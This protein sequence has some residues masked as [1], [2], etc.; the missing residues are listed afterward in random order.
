MDGRS[1]GRPAGYHR[2]HQLGVLR[3]GL[4]QPSV[5]MKAPAL[6]E[7]SLTYVNV[8]AV[9]VS[10]PWSMCWR[11]EAICTVLPSL[12]GVTH[13]H[14]EQRCPPQVGQPIRVHPFL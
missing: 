14:I 2:E 9:A 4:S 8:S 11:I 7:I 6:Q 1:N 10:T 13:D 3:R 12:G 5:L